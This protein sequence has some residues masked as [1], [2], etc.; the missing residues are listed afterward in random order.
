MFIS[1]RIFSMGLEYNNK[2]ILKLETG[3][4]NIRERKE[5]KT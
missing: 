3:S 1:I 4:K 2:E 5:V